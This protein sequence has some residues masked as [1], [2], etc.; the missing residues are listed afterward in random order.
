MNILMAVH[1]LPPH[2]SG[3]AEWRTIRT[4]VALQQRGHRVRVVAIE[5]IRGEPGE[6]VTWF[7]EV[8][9]GVQVRRLSFDMK[10]APD[11]FRWQYDN[12]WVGAHIEA[13]MRIE[14][15]DLFHMIG[16]YLITAS[17]LN[18]AFR[19]TIPAVV[20]LTDY[21][22]ICP[23]I[24]LL[25]SDGNLSTLPVRAEQCVRC[26]GEEKRRFRLPGQ[27]LPGLMDLYWRQQHDSI[28]RIDDRLSYL[29]GTL[30]QAKAILC[31]SEFLRG[32]YAQMGID[33]E[34][35]YYVRQGR[36]FPGLTPEQVRKTPSPVL[37]IG[38]IG[39]IAKLKGV[40]VLIEAV[41]SLPGSALKLDIYGDLDAFPKYSAELRRRIG[42]DNRIR[43]AGT[44]QHLSPTLQEIDVVVVPSLW[45]ENSPNSILEAFAHCTPVLTSNLGGMSE[46]VHEGVNGLLF[47][48]GDAADLAQK[49]RCILET[50]DILE[51][52]RG[53]IQ[54]IKGLDAEMDE[55][56]A[57]YH[58]AT[59]C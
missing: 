50:P 25:R 7:D 24:S 54:P 51:R 2:Y 34:R 20:S 10:S 12:P 44:Y 45:Y 28:Q 21:W 39:Q 57:I 59:T 31:P 37:R 48:P 15:P 11:L 5:S 6:G 40:H 56:E 35:M 52:L 29:L 33:R 26:L 18:A 43:L 3:G 55:L 13:L 49:I 1:H 23:R 42:T 38:Y 17:A 53:N 14:Q 30:N 58:D 9:E 27:V 46:L 19:A 22:W 32:V 16:G 4:A 36:D 47:A 8:Y 41:R